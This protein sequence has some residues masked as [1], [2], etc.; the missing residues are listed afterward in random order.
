[1]YYFF[2]AIKCINDFTVGIKINPLTDAIFKNITDS[3]FMD[4]PKNFLKEMN[5][6]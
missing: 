4:W 5:E 6:N 3:G 2:C 1:M